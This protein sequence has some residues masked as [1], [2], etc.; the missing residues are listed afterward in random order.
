M[1]NM[2]NITSLFFEIITSFGTIEQFPF[3]QHLEFFQN[4]DNLIDKYSIS[5][6]W[7]EISGR[8]YFDTLIKGSITVTGTNYA[9]K[10][11]PYQY[12]FNAQTMM[13]GLKHPC[14]SGIV[15]RS[16]AINEKELLQLVESKFTYSYKNCTF[17]LTQSSMN[18]NVQ[19][20]INRDSDSWG[21]NYDVLQGIILPSYPIIAQ[22]EW[23][24]FFN[25]FSDAQEAN[26]ELAVTLRRFLMFYYKP[27]E[28]YA[29]L[30]L[31]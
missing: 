29:S 20:C 25:I 2:L 13:S 16:G 8:N 21:V 11:C 26:G 10:T 23:D 28:L 19:K 27:T 6:K 1:A 5:N 3:I 30:K 7:S 31:Q 24:E 14:D 4:D 12:D 17:V 22:A 15:S 9:L 18:E